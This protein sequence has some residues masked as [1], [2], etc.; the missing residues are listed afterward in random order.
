MSQSDDENKCVTCFEAAFVMRQNTKVQLTSLI[1]FPKR[2][3][4]PQKLFLCDEILQQKNNL[5]QD[6]SRS[7][8][9]NAT[10]RHSQGS[11][12]EI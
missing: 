4:F 8:E 9:N 1:W 3:K 12:L 5:H 10:K 2:V 7:M 6:F 11:D